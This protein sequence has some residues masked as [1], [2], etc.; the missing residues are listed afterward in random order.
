MLSEVE[1]KVVPIQCPYFT[2]QEVSEVDMQMK[3]GGQ[4]VVNVDIQ[5][6]CCS[7]KYSWEKGLDTSAHDNCSEG[8]TAGESIAR[9]WRGLG[10]LIVKK[11]KL[12][13]C[14]STHSKHHLALP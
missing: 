7:W 4:Q 8:I 12:E 13:C 3:Y 1:S 6:G 9:K 10:T 11:Q 2:N 14:F 5:T